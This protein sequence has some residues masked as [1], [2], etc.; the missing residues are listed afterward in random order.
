MNGSTA[1]RVIVT[2]AS[3]HIGFHVAKALLA[4]GYRTELLLRQRNVLTE[5][6]ERAGAIVH[7]DN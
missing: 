2:G 1:G 7:V 4:R 3:G 6:L 5:R